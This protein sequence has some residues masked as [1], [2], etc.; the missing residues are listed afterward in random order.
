MSL[1]YDLDEVRHRPSMYLPSPHFD[2]AAAYVMGIDAACNGGFLEGFREWLIPMVNSGNNLAWTELVLRIAF[3][4]TN[5]PRD[6]I[7]Q[8]SDS[9]IAIECLFHC[10]EEFLTTK[11]QDKGLRFIH[12]RYQKW[13]RSQDWYSSSEPIGDNRTES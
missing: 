10:L 9:A 11:Q 3:P 7:H 6:L 12:E 2:V 4:Q 13:L 1:P 5:N 8:S